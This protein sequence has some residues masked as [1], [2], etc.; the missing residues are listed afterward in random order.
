[1][2]ASRVDQRR[3]FAARPA[4]PVRGVLK[5][6]CCRRRGQALIE[7]ALVA[8]VTYLLLAAI[9]TFGFLF[10][11]AQVAQS[12][13]EAGAR[14]LSRTP[15]PADEEFEVVMAGGDEFPQVK[16]NVFDRNLLVFAVPDFPTASGEQNMADVVAGWPALNQQLFPLMF[17]DPQLR[18]GTQRVLRYPGTLVQSNSTESGYDVLIPVLNL[19]GF[20]YRWVYP[21][22]EIDTE[23]TF[24]G[25]RGDNGPV[26][27]RDPFQ[28]TSERMGT[29]ALRVNYP[30]QTSAMTAHVP[31]PA[32]P[33]EP[34]V[35]NPIE[36]TDNYATDSLPAGM[37]LLDDRTLVDDR[38]TPDTS[39]DV[40]TGPHGGK[41]GLGAHGAMGRVVR[42]FRRV[43]STQAIYRREVFD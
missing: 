43:I 8:L 31:N 6:S 39:D 34:T 5:I 21:V 42:P 25:Q 15:L 17:V 20:T 38:S 12:A 1:M 23:N 13:A 10:F 19:D 33:Y 37:T 9:L 16:S 40:Y 7:F 11:A 3:Q 28:I 18:I 2:P 26:P 4:G 36:T 29:V 32:G 30:F 24:L 14:E 35:G 41:Y 27:N 22:E